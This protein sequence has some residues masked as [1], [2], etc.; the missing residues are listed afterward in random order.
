[1]ATSSH[2]AA[3]AKGLTGPMDFFGIATSLFVIDGFGNVEFTGNDEALAQ[4]AGD[5]GL[6]S[7][8]PHIG[9]VVIEN[10][11]VPGT[12]SSIGGRR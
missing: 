1:M 6:S 9:V 12:W 2:A 4:I 10:E 8:Q 3:A 7:A 5:R 11:G